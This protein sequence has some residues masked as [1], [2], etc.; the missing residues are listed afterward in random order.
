MD[1]TTPTDV[2]LA[3]CRFVCSRADF[4]RLLPG[5]EFEIPVPQELGSGLAPGWPLRPP[6]ALT[7]ALVEYLSAQVKAALKPG[8]PDAPDGY[9]QHLEA[10]LFDAVAQAPGARLDTILW[11]WL[12]DF[13]PRLL[14][15]DE[16][17]F[18]ELERAHP[19]VVQAHRGPFDQL[20]RLGRRSPAQQ[21]S[22][23]R[24]ILTRLDGSHEIVASDLRQRAGEASE[25]LLAL[26][27]DTPVLQLAPPGRFEADLDLTPIFLGREGFVDD[28]TFTL[29][30]RV[31]Q[32]I[33]DV[34]WRRRSANRAAAGERWA[35]N[36]FLPETTLARAHRLPAS[37][38]P[39]DA[40]DDEAVRVA[41]LGALQPD[42]VD[43][44]LHHADQFSVDPETAARYGVRDDQ[45]GL[46]A[47]PESLALRAG[48]YR[49]VVEEL[50]RWDVLDTAR[51]MVH[52]VSVRGDGYVLHGR[53]VGDRV[54][55]LDLEEAPPAP[56]P[57]QTPPPE[58]SPVDDL[59]ADLGVDLGGGGGDLGLG[60]GWSGDPS[61]DEP[62]GAFGDLFSG[63]S[64]FPSFDADP[65]DGGGGGYDLGAGVSGLSAAPSA[66]RRVTPKA[67]SLLGVLEADFVTVLQE[68]ELGPQSLP[69]EGMPSVRV[70]KPDFETLFEGYMIFPVGRLGRP[71]SSIGID[72]RHRDQLFDLHL[73]PVPQDPA[74]RPEQAVDEFMRAKVDANFVPLAF[75]YVDI[76]SDAG[77]M[78]PLSHHRLER[79]F[80]RVARPSMERL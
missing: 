1:T 37:A 16:A 68:W 63:D 66:P 3:A 70:S 14:D 44:L 39:P 56:V 72:R 69:P 10:A 80:Q 73:F 19:R 28:E 24:G 20:D 31:V 41:T 57:E 42:L 13:V 15:A 74:W 18:A 4:D 26:S 75:E 58:S 30:R 76:P 27:G 35:M 40:G 43:Y 53:P 29:T 21:A 8:S 49:D 22:L 36:Y 25:H 2:V 38:L 9:F 45:L 79:A 51:G 62:Y 46:L 55:V 59:F 78:E 65:A 11:L 5:L 32:S 7:A 48:G 60:G 64:G 34:S 77:A 33:I 23:K 67:L 6:S 61:G 12:L 50:L 71:G 52:R 17:L 47:D 54:L